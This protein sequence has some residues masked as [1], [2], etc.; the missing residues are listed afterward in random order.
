MKRHELKTWTQYFQDI[1]HNNKRFELRVNDRE[2]EVK[3]ILKLKEWDNTNERYTGDFITAKVD[4]IL[5]GGKFGLPEN[6]CIMSF[7]I[8]N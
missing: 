5:H 2:F 7:T 3:D 8:L 4:Y 1:K 6:M